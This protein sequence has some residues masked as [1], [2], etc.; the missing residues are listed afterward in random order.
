MP[1]TADHWRDSVIL[2]QWL[3]KLNLT[4]NAFQLIRDKFG[5]KSF[6]LT[7]ILSILIAVLSLGQ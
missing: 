4:E 7:I 6:N 3:E 2:R 5:I 1:A